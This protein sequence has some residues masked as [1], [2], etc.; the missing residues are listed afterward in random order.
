MYRGIQS[1]NG[2][3]SAQSPPLKI[4]ID[5][6]SH[7]AKHMVYSFFFW[8]PRIEPGGILIIEDVQPIDEANLFRT[9]FL[10]QLMADL[11]FCGDPGQKK[12]EACFPQLYPLL[13]SIHCEMH[14]CVFERNNSPAQPNLSIESS[15]PPPN[16]L[17]MNQCYT[18]SN[19]F[20]DGMEA[21]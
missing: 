19:V 15:K 20:G 13:Q 7:L 5:D 16:A 4:V 1:P 6:G 3:T 18:F 17:D 2:S 9:Q 11:H 14:I 10:P 21:V 12:D 8:F